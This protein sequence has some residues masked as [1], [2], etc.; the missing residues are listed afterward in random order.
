MKKTNILFTLFFLASLIANAGIS[1]NCV[2]EALEAQDFFEGAGMT[3]E[4]ANM[5]A[6][7]AYD[8]C[9][10]GGSYNYTLQYSNGQ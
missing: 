8:A 10:A 9:E 7:R 3:M 4:V 2:Q 5:H 1:R 6:N